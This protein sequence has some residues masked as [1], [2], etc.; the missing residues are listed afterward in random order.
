LN[1]QR[2]DS[3]PAIDI[4]EAEFF[5]Y[6]E[7]VLIR[8]D[9]KMKKPAQK[10]LVLAIGIVVGLMLIA[11]CEE[12]QS[13]PEMKVNAKES[14]KMSRIIAM[15]N[16]QLKKKI[17]I[18]EKLHAGEM[19]RLKEQHAAEMERQKRVLDT[20]LQEKKSL[21]EMS[22]KGIESYMEGTLGPVVD[23]NLKLRE[24][25]ESFKKQIK[26]FQGERYKLMAEIKQ[27]RERLEKMKAAGA[28][29]VL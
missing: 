4:L 2:L 27:L 3:R 28:G 21:E 8:K 18:Q 12:E 10:T 29:G 9:E 6:L 26:R 22:S 5:W 1:S 7:N 24:E 15:Q 20:C 16:T 19:K 14:T 13:P 11:G 17:E 23:E 25:N